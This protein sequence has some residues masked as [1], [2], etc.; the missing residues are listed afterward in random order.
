VTVDIANTEQA[1]A[2]NGD[3]GRDWTDHEEA[4][5][6][7][8]RRQTQ[9]LFDR[10]DIG[11]SANVLDIGCGCGETTRL[12]ARRARR[13]S[14]SGIDISAPMTARAA[15]RAR[16]E[17]IENV[18][19]F[20]GD[21]QMYRFPP[22]AYDVAISRYGAM[23]FGDPEAAFRNIGN[24]IRAGGS[25]VMLTW[26]G[27]DGN[28]WVQVI[29]NALAAGRDLPN[30]PAS[31]CGPFS[32]ADAART[33]SLLNQAGFENVELAGVV[34]PV[35]LGDS[36][37]AAFDFISQQGIC[38]G[39]LHGL[40]HETRARA[41]DE[42]RNVFVGHESTDGVLLESGSWLVSATRH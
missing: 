31:G 8:V 33:T 4:Y 26:Q 7:C 35:Y 36:A 15:A 40:G 28:P 13:G 38:R 3:D 25:L 10:A 22:A 5:N 14:A 30:P 21:A 2:W 19:F 17:D 18:E 20:Q 11:E 16:A 12:A 1:A 6:A 37:E 42:L 29:R 32:L 39:L 34:E 24:A 41:L 23:F 27:L 9:L